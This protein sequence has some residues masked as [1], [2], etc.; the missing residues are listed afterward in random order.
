VILFSR[1]PVEAKL[2]PIR[3]ALTDYE[4]VFGEFLV[5]ALGC[6]AMEEE[7]EGLRRKNEVEN[8]H[9]N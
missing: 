1:L 8:R 5:E 9:G 2:R 6:R 3:G 7:V 4:R